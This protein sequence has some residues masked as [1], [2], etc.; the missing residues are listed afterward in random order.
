MTAT[1]STFGVEEEFHILD[2]ATGRLAPGSATLLT[3]SDGAEKEF[4]RSMVETATPVCTDLDELRAELVASRK[5]LVAAADRAGL[6]VVA[7]GTVPDSG[8]ATAPVYPDDRYRRIRDRYQKLAVEQQVCATQVQVGVEHPD[9]AV[10]IIPRLRGWLPTLLALSASSPYFQHADTGYASYRNIVASRWPTAGPP[11]VFPDHAAYRR[12]VR[13]LIDTG[14]I[15]D[16]R[17]IYYDARVSARY[18][19]LELRICDSTPR[20][21]DVVLLAGLG[22][23]LVATAAAE[24]EAGAPP[25]DVPDEL[26]RAATWTAA[27]DGLRDRLVDPVAGEA[28]KA[29]D[30]VGRLVAHVRP[31]LEAAGDLGTVEAGVADL[32]HR[33]TSAESQRR[34]LV[35]GGGEAGVTAALAA[36]TRQG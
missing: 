24:D 14:V 15:D 28:V 6:C 8:V 18:P 27:R 3:D 19:T 9:L 35:S 21:D 2:A 11:P 16:A 7:A 22:R 29:A 31:A 33:G 34:S 30:L 1:A 26:L 36:L 4:Q 10:R 5:A 32:L 12:S 23:A 25:A 17:M 20:L 13:R